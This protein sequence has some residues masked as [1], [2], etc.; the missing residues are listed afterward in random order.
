MLRLQRS[1]THVLPFD[2]SFPGSACARCLYLGVFLR[3]TVAVGAAGPSHL[4]APRVWRTCFL[5]WRSVPS[6]QSSLG[7]CEWITRNSESAAAH[8]NH[9]S[10]KLS[11]RRG[12]TTRLLPISLRASVW[13]LVDGGISVLVCR[14][15]TWNNNLT[16][17]G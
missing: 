12:A 2:H 17:S 3:R 5:V 4:H 14:D 6:R 7:E 16:F 1:P 10:E 9:M 8:G 13:Q 15:R 11:T